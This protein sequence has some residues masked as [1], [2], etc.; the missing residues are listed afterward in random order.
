[1]TE[2]LAETHQ[3][4]RSTPSR[5]PS[6]ARQGRLWHRRLGWVGAAALLLFGLSGLTHPLMTWFG[7]QPTAFFP[8]Q[9]EFDATQIAAIPKIL[10]RHGI[11]SAQQVR[12]VPSV[13]GSTL[14]I[15]SPE[16]PIRRYFDLATGSELTDFDRRQA[17][18]LARYY[19]GVSDTPLRSLTLQ[20]AFDNAYPEVNRLLPVWKVTFDTEDGLT[21]FIHTELNA[22]AALGNHLRATQQGL[23]RNLHSLSWL[24]DWEALRVI[25]LT[26]LTLTL[27]GLGLAGMVLVFALPARQIPSNRH[28]WHRHLGLVLWVPLLAFATSG[29]CHLLHNAGESH[30]AGFAPAQPLDLRPLQQGT[31]ISAALHGLEHAGHER[32]H[33]TALNSVSLLSDPDGNLLLRLAHPAG[34]ADEH[35]HQHA[36]FNGTPTG[37]PSQLIALTGTAATRWSDRDLA[38]H[39]AAAHLKI[40]VSAIT[41]TELV[42]HFGPDYDFRNKRL[43]VWRV[44]HASGSA[45]IDPANGALVD[46]ASRP[47][48]WEGLSF[49]HLHKWNFLT[50][51][52]GR[53]W[54]DVIVTLVVLSMLGSTTLGLSMMARRRRTPPAVAAISYD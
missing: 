40:D 24:D 15:T 50:P 47:D 2:T 54:R 33:A 28:R 41:G 51:I 13:T 21:A 34:R 37:Q 25:I 49:S 48:R 22:L 5:R 6:W 38:R 36:R 39:F 26:G 11:E 31:D 17:E 14:Q 46:H 35:V 29:L 23:F 8:P 43:P 3:V 16:Q 44:R 32:E 12:M 30:G 18:W 45:F 7:P 20:T 27:L 10:S 9:A 4:P 42:T 53:E 1:M 52:T 19:T